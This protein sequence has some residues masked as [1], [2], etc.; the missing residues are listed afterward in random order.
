[1]QVILPIRDVLVEGDGMAVF[2]GRLHGPMTISRSCFS[3]ADPPT[4]PF[5]IFYLGFADPI[6]HSR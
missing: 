4:L 3:Q 2:G 5:L 6:L 1:M